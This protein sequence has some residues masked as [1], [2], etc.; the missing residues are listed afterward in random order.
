MTDQI[1]F[2][3]YIDS[4]TSEKSKRKQIKIAIATKGS[5]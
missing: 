2:S 1:R 4:F 3:E 5:S